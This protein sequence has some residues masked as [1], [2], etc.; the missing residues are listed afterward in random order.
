MDTSILISLA[1]PVFFLMIG[2][3]LIYGYAVGN[4][5]Y[6]LNDSIAA[7]SLGLISRLPPMLNLGVQGI[8]WSSIATN[9]NL[10]LLPTDSW[11]TWVVAFVLYDVCY[12]WMHRLSHEIKVL[13]ATHVVHH[14]GEEFN[15]STALRQSSSGW[16]WKWIF[17]TPM[18]F[19]GV[20][21][22][23]FF[24]VAAANLLYQFWVHTEHI[25]KLGVLEY[26]LVTPSNHRVHHAQNAEYIDANY[27]GVFI[28]WDRIFG[29]FIEEKDE[30]KPIYGTV[31]PLRSW[32]P[33]WSNLEIYHQ[34]FRDSFHTKGIRN[35]IRVWF[36]GTGWRPD[37][38]L[39][40]FPHISNDLNNFEKYD[41]ACDAIKKTYSLIQFVINSIISVVLI[42]TVSNQSYL[43]TFGIAV[44][45]VFSTSLV[46]LILENKQWAINL[47]IVRALFVMTVYLL[48]AH[49]TSILTV[50]WFFYQA[51]FSFIYLAIFLPI[52]KKSTYSSAE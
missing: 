41:P 21:G 33:I 16:L 35:K 38:V 12:Y 42:F 17:Y 45:L 52:N 37:D 26:V 36:S 22:E 32:N 48:F 9:Y 18:F 50:E 51:V 3:E 34:M 20:P 24:T 1:I 46:N 2:I 10:A 40:K 30:L 44:M 8:V 6:R 11:I 47:E 19:I 7:I 5:N 25:R 13:W 23:V 27:G 28:L 49:K 43:V 15:L 31:K 29:S 39:E 14:Q 4:N